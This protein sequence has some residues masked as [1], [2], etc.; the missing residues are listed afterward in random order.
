MRASFMAVMWVSERAK[1]SDDSR[2]QLSARGT[3][4]FP[5][6]STLFECRL[7]VAFAQYC[8]YGLDYM[9]LEW[10]TLLPHTDYN[11]HRP[12]LDSMNCKTSA[13]CN[14][15][16]LV[17]TSLRGAQVHTYKVEDV[18]KGRCLQIMH[19]WLQFAS[20]ESAEGAHS[21]NSEA[22]AQSCAI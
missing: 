10:L 13:D 12:K 3:S 18:I 20:E 7:A 4:V 21:A 17:P 15:V 2:N 1:C 9:L 19:G 5:C 8:D 22:T 14:S 16:Q 6:G 11:F